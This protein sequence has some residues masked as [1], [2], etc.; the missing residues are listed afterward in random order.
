MLAA[1]SPLLPPEFAT[2][3]DARFGRRWSLA[4]LGRN[5]RTHAVRLGDR[6][7]AVVKTIRSDREPH[8]VERAFRLLRTHGVACPALLTAIRAPTGWL[9]LFEHVDGVEPDPSSLAWGDT[10]SA[11]LSVLPRLAGIRERIAAWDLEREWLAFVAPA[12][13]EYEAA[14]E[15][16]ERLRESE[17][18]GTAC[19]AHGDFAPQNFVVGDR[20]VTLVDWEDLGYARPGFDAGWLLSLNRVGAGPRW[21]HDVLLR[22]FVDMDIA[23]ANLRWFEAIG[24]L[25]MHARAHSWTDRPLERTVVLETV[26]YAIRS[27]GLSPALEA[28]ANAGRAWGR[29]G[30]A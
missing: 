4:P 16:L 28:D 8:D 3:I 19:L 21:P 18:G 10:W 25:R 27:S 20:G 6:A 23:P 11:A 29:S 2:Q 17:P 14:N 22:K 12:A 30:G 26:R 24:L 15:L 1:T 5:R 13:V 9:A 7:V